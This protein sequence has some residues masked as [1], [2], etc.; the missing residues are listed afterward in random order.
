MHL[1]P[2]SSA[3]MPF[4][5]HICLGDTRGECKPT[6]RFQFVR[7]IFGNTDVARNLP[8][9]FEHFLQ[10]TTKMPRSTVSGITILRC[11][12][13]LVIMLQIGSSLQSNSQ[14]GPRSNASAKSAKIKPLKIPLIFFFPGRGLP[15]QQGY[16]SPKF[17]LLQGKQGL[18][19]SHSLLPE[20]SR[21]CLECWLQKIALKN[22]RVSCQ[23]HARCS[24]KCSH[25]FSNFATLA[26][27]RSM[28]CSR[29]RNLSCTAVPKSSYLAF[30]VDKPSCK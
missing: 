23:I 17:E 6:P 25:S 28:C 7:G 12:N 15:K 24:C 27:V 4:M 22:C 5:H 9:V 14:T 26:C 10:P 8:R 30:N 2:G 19:S 13:H 16:L 21:P 29:W 1:L 18:P 3:P 11:P 20:L